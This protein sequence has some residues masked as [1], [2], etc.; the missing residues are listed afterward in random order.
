MTISKKIH[1]S[2]FRLT[3]LLG[4]L[5]FI[6]F[7]LAVYIFVPTGY[8]WEH[9][10]RPAALRLLS[11]VSPYGPTNY[12][13]APWLLLPLLPLSILPSHIGFTLFTILG[14]AVISYLAFRFGARPWTLG[15]L[16]L[17]YPVTKCLYRGQID[18]VSL[19]G[20]LL[21]AQY[22][23]FLVLAKPQIGIGVAIFWLADA[24]RSGGIRRVTSTFIPVVLAYLIS[25]PIFGLW[26]LLPGGIENNPENISLW[27]I[28]LFLGLIFLI[29]A[30]RRTSIRSSIISSPFLSPYL[31]VY[32]LTGVFIALVSLPILE[33]GIS[34]VLWALKLANLIR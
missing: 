27:P 22:G 28:S 18:W 26:F 1:S 12:F 19:S 9:S 5:A 29:L 34:V 20:V 16:L 24:Y 10:F 31:C 15:I 6:L 2:E 23:L 25:I 13:N 32:S 30:I 33:V 11:G 17:S 7:F 4:L 14:I 21:P 8:E 3:F